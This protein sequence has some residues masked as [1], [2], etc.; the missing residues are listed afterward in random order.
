VWPARRRDV[1]AL[2]AVAIGAPIAA[3]RIA[4]GRKN[5]K[6]PLYFNRVALAYRE[7]ESEQ[8]CAPL[9]LWILASKSG[10]EWNYAE[11]LLPAAAHRANIR[12]V[13]SLAVSEWPRRGR[14]RARSFS[15]GSSR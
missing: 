3:L 2:L 11:T 7:V 15:F 13:R 9:K 1:A 4:H 8:T 14:S 5:W 6:K 12:R 10:T